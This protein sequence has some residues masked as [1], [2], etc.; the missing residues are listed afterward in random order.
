MKKLTLLLNISLILGTL[1]F[2]GCE[3]DE[4]TT[5]PV[6]S[7]TASLLGQAGTADEVQVTVGSDVVYEFEVQSEAEI[8]KIE[9]WRYQGTDINKSEP[10]L[11]VIMEYP[12]VEIGTTYSVKDTIEALDTDVRYSIYVQDMNDAYTSAQVNLFLDVTRYSVSLTDGMS[13]GSSPTFLNVESGRALY[14]G[15]TISDPV[16][17]DLGFAYLEGQETVKACLVSF[18]EYYKTG[19]YATVVNDNNN[20]TLFKD[21][22]A[23][24]GSFAHIYDAVANASQLTGY[25]SNAAD[26]STPLDFANGS[27][28]ADLAADNMIAFVTDDGRHGL[29]QITAVDDKSGSL[30]NDQTI[31]FD[32]IVQ[33]RD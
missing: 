17:I 29:I 28:A 15:N 7:A 5:M 18:D 11:E 21:A 20:S 14:V 31:S 4:I 19:N 8:K 2:M 33:K 13:N 25:Y 9:I 6:I 3:K 10:T 16:G 30:S 22:S 23:I 32:V 1:S 26:I 27:I 12:A 24:S